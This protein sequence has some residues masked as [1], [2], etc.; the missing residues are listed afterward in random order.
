[1]KVFSLCASI[2]IC[3]PEPIG[4]SLMS[5]NV[6]SAVNNG[7]RSVFCVVVSW[8]MWSSLLSSSPAPMQ[9]NGLYK[10]FDS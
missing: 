3:L 10:T 5:S 4:L 2:W 8:C 1:M 6:V 7:E 9:E